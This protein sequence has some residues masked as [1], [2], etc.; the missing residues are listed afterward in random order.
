DTG[1]SAMML[2]EDV[3]QW[4]AANR[5]PFEWRSDRGPDG[6]RLAILRPPLGQRLPMGDLDVAVVVPDVHLGFGNDVFRFGDPGRAR[7]LEAFL[8]LL[9]RLR[10]RVR[11]FGALQVGDWYDF[12]RAP[13]AGVPAKRALIEQQYRTVYERARQL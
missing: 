6:V 1:G 4:F 10:D 12:W 7:R 3:R 9:A 13:A 11:S 2:L 5:M 8:D